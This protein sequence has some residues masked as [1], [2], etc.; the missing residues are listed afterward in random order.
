MEF[1]RSWK[2]K[3]NIE[4]SK[5]EKLLVKSKQSGIQKLIMF[6]LTIIMW[7]YSFVVVCFFLSA[8]FEF[9][10][11][12]VSIVKVALNISN[13][14]IKNFIMISLIWFIG[15][16]LLLSLWRIYNKKRFGSLR[17]RKSPTN[18]TKEEMLQLGLISEVTYDELQNKT[19]IV[20]EKNPVREIE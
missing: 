15:L 1:T 8:I 3:F 19:I 4:E 6:V 13:M 14:E 5:N 17:R 16:F 18:T 12:F 7:F 9:N 2:A 20:F 10:N 11:E